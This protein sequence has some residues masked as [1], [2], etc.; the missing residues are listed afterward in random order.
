[1]TNSFLGK[2]GYMATVRGL[3]KDVDS[4]LLAGCPLTLMMNIERRKGKDV[5]VIKKYLVDLDRNPFK[6]FAEV[7]LNISILF[8]STNDDTLSHDQHTTNLSYIE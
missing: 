6:L 1:M 5:P 7:C 4:W 8:Y 3:N 2:T